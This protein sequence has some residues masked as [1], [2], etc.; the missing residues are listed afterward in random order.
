MASV[1]F[2]W[3]TLR[4]DGYQDR[5]I[6]VG[7][8]VVYR[9]VIIARG[10]II[11][12]EDVDDSRDIGDVDK[13]VAIDIDGLER[14]LRVGFSQEDVDDEGDIADV[15]QAVAVGISFDLCFFSGV[16]R[17]CR[18]ACHQRMAERQYKQKQQQIRLHL[19][20][21]FRIRSAYGSHRRVRGLR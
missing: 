4:R 16:K 20:L 15:D 11:T 8:I 10:V 17:D 12:Q 14:I 7:I 6:G 9:W 18:C 19:L 21:K 13:S 1:G 5:E 3:R 2:R